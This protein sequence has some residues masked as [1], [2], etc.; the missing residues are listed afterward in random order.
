[1]K[2]TLSRRAVM[3]GGSAL[4][5]A[6]L[7]ARAGAGAGVDIQPPLLSRLPWPYLKLD[8]D[9]T[10]QRAYASF[11][12]GGCM[13]GV[14]EAVAAQ[15][16]EGLG[17]PFTQFPFKLSAYGGGGVAMWG[18]L[19][20]TCNGA[21]MA[22]ALFRTGAAQSVLASE[23]L[24]WYEQTPLPVFTPNEPKRVAPG[25][26]M[27]AS[28]AGSNLCHVSITRWVRKT[29]FAS[30]SPER[31]ERCARVAAD[32][33][34]RVAELLNRPAVADAGRQIGDQAGSCLGC[35]AMG[36]QAPGEPEVVSQM[37]CTTCHEPHETDAS[38]VI[39]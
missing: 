33:A 25:F 9:R 16:A 10:R 31:L 2:Q 37:E 23:L 20:G 26:E 22:L 38:T 32:V 12:E 29:G 39:E 6:W 30:F 8:A 5:A 1:M 35:H 34:G 36:R 28:R 7:G 3:A 13:Y 21:A 14:F 27:P 17:D 19:C 24:A 15:V 4:G 18:T 11:F